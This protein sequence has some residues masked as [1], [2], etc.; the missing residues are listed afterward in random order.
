MKKFT[1]SSLMILFF[2]VGVIGVSSAIPITAVTADTFTDGVLLSPAHKWNQKQYVMFLDA[3]STHNQG[4]CIALDLGGI[5]DVDN[6][7]IQAGDNDIN[8]FFYHDLSRNGTSYPT[9]EIQIYDTSFLGIPVL[10]E[11][12]E[13]TGDYSSGTPIV[14][15]KVE[16]FGKS[17]GSEQN[18]LASEIQADGSRVP[19][20]ATML[21][22]GLGLTGLS[23]IRSR[24]SL[25]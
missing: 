2:V 17:L 15:N 14:T 3:N 25:S 6:Y 24:R 21:L 13:N 1:I 10:P 5:F 16:L 9:W 4:S 23:R 18:F 11:P 20:P 19:E 8:T 22:F 7:I 12:Y